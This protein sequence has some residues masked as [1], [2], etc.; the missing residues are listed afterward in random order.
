MRPFQ[1]KPPPPG[2][3]DDGDASSER[4]G[5]GEV[6]G[7]KRGKGRLPA[8]EASTGHPSSPSP[9]SDTGRQRDDGGGVGNVAA[10]DDDNASVGSRSVASSQSL[11]S[12][13]SKATTASLASY[14][15]ASIAT[16]R[17]AVRLKRHSGAGYVVPLM[18]MHTPFFF[19]FAASVTV[20]RLVDLFTS[21]SLSP[22]DHLG[23]TFLSAL[24]SP[25]PP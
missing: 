20:P 5:N 25:P 15:G 2:G 10:D 19:L 23:P 6:V 16:R 9:R 12:L 3:N 17:E 7:K 14:D 8:I 22:R 18:F 11:Q 24:L 13:Q 4:G 1:R 21:L